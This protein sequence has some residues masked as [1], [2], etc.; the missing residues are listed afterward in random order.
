MPQLIT[1]PKCLAVASLLSL[2]AIV[3]LFAVSLPSCPKKSWVL[4]RRLSERNPAEDNLQE[5]PR[6]RVLRLPSCG[7]CHS[8]YGHR[9]ELQMGQEGWRSI[10]SVL[11][12]SR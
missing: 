7:Q 1:Y 5:Y 8:I 3:Y 10:G 11:H 4:H 6:L 9:D 12:G 2:L